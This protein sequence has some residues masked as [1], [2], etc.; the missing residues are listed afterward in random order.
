MVVYYIENRIKEL[1]GM[2]KLMEY[3]LEHCHS[4]KDYAEIEAKLDKYKYA[5]DEI[6]LIYEKI[7]EYY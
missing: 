3:N 4:K 5:L 2:I 7:K 1:N 6:L